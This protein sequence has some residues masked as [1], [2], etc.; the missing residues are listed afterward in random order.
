[1]TH[2]NAM[3]PEELRELVWDMA[4][5][6]LDLAQHLRFT[7]EM[8]R[9]DLKN[10]AYEKAIRMAYDIVKMPDSDYK[11]RDPRCDVVFFGAE[12]LTR[13]DITLDDLIMSVGEI[14]KEKEDL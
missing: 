2:P 10:G 1:M 7:H 8:L 13:P 3:L 12:G 6:A 11:K 4:N 9:D 14:M 5:A